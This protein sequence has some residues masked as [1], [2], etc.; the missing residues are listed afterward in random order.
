MQNILSSPLIAGMP[1]IR[2]H[3]NKDLI[4]RVVSRRKH[5]L[6]VSG[7]MALRGILCCKGDEATG[8][9]RKV[10]R[11]VLDSFLPSNIVR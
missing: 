8:G 6:R 5:R 2:I 1:K 11:E 9:W 4:L 7:N 10:T 3:E